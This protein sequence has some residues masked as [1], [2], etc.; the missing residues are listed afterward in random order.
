[1]PLRG[2][3]RVRLRRFDTPDCAGPTAVGEAASVEVIPRDLESHKPLGSAEVNLS[4][5]GITGR[6]DPKGL[7]CLTQSP[8]TRPMA[9][10][11]YRCP[12]PGSCPVLLLDFWK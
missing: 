12:L 9:Y 5:K 2:Q 7:N 6:R 4:D 11:R 1:M 10:G 3:R 8:E